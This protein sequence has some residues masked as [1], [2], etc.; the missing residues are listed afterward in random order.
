M[1][2]PSWRI[3]QGPGALGL[4]GPQGRFELEAAVAPQRAEDI[5]G[6]ALAVDADEC[7]AGIGDGPA[8]LVQPADGTLAQGDVRLGADL[9]LVGDQVKGAGGQ[10]YVE[11]HRPADEPVAPQAVADEVGDAAH[12]QPV[13]GAELLQVRHPGHGA[14]LVH[15]LADDGH[16]LQPG[17]AGQV[18]RP[19]GLA[20]ADQ[21][22]AVAC[23]QREDVPGADEVARLGVVPAGQLHRPGPVGRRYA[24]GDARA[25]VDGHG[26]GRAEARGVLRG[27]RVQ[28]QG[29]GLLVGHGQADQPAPVA[30]HEVDD[31][32][33]DLLGC[34]DQIPLVLACLVVHQHD[35]SAGTDV[36]QDVL[37]R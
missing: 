15:D 18:H 14:V 13:G 1:P 28:A 31:L 20:G 16:G 5:S 25:G 22:P 24:G 11:L 33:G 6:E 17:Q 4:D 9:R 37:N 8:G 30:G 32:G 2:R 27:L 26:E 19:L 29:V 34:A 3:D 12:L 23:S 21:H 35:Q 36:F 10:G 7:L